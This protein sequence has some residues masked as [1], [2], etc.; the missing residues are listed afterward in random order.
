MEALLC[1]SCPSPRL[2]RADMGVPGHATG[3][4][5][6]AGA[7]GTSLLL[8]QGCSSAWIG[9]HNIGAAPCCTAAPTTPCTAC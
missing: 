4:D 9:V 6:A 7:A 1:T 3:G 2:L 8:V 5:A